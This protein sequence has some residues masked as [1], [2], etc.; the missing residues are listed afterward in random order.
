MREDR[1]RDDAPVRA[2]LARRRLRPA[3]RAREPRREG[4][5]GRRRG[6]LPF[7]PTG[8][9]GRAPPPRNGTEHGRAGRERG[10]A[11]AGRSRCGEASSGSGRRRA[12]AGKRAAVRREPPAAEPD[13]GPR[14]GRGERADA[15]PPFFPLSTSLSRPPRAPV[16]THRSVRTTH[17]R[18]G[19]RASRRELE[20]RGRA[21][22]AGRATPPPPLAER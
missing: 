4:G 13:T 10:D 11:P 22:E 17:A 1:R 12:R 21:G 9:N 7:P 15:R 2:T 14:T 20:E 5:A 18:P 3:T 16:R 6:A 8:G 19:E